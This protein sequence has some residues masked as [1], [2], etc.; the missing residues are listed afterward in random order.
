MGVAAVVGQCDHPALLGGKSVDRREQFAGQ[1]APVDLARRVLGRFEQVLWW[2]I[3]AVGK[4][5]SDALAQ[6]IDRAVTHDSEQ[7]CSDA[8]LACVEVAA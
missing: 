8:A 6:N 5:V 4:L 1:L 7:P 3:A 2:A